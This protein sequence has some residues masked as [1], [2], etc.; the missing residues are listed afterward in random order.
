MGNKAYDVTGSPFIG[1][2]VETVVG[3]L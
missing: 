3:S 1:A 2:A